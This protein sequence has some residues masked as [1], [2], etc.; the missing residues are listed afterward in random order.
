MHKT[1]C[2]A[3]KSHEHTVCKECEALGNRLTCDKCGKFCSSFNR[4]MENRICR[5][6]CDKCTNKR[7]TCDICEVKGKTRRFDYNRTEC[8]RSDCEKLTKH[9]HLECI[10]CETSSMYF[11]N[12]CYK[13]KAKRRNKKFFLHHF[14]KR[15]NI[16]DCNEQRQHEHYLCKE[17]N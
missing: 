15:C 5:L 9:M 3:M 11:Q 14:V 17:C 10:G 6:V 8:I 12:Y 7:N 2:E 4:I 16:N 13:C 1:G